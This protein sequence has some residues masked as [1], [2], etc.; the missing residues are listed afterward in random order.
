MSKGRKKALR[1]FQSL[2]EREFGEGYEWNGIGVGKLT[3]LLSVG[4]ASHPMDLSPHMVKDLVLALRD[5]EDNNWCLALNLYGRR[6][7]GHLH[8]TL[9]AEECVEAI[10]LIGD[11]PKRRIITW[12]IS[13]DKLLGL[14]EEEE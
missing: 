9:V 14:R 13:I 12:F 1:N 4:M 2:L 10:L 5:C 7:K 11:G 8:I 3:N 6:W